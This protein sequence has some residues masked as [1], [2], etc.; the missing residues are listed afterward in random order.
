MESLQ[1][2][3]LAGGLAWASGIR[4][5]AAVFIA[6]VLGRLGYVHLPAGLTML[7]D[8][9]VIGV[10]AVLML[11]EFLAD[12]IPAFDSVWDA[13]H[14]FIRIPAGMLLAWGVFKDSGP[15]MQFAAALIGG[16]ITSGTHLTK[17]GTRALINTSPEPFSNWGASLVEDAS[18]LGGLYLVWAHPAI[19]LVLLVLFLA[20]ALWLLPKLFRGLAALWRR[21]RGVP[22]P[23]PAA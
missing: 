13:L 18:L 20:F 21:F 6:G 19:F 11:G 2:I 5:Y 9:W 1:N 3:A 8:D 4:L 16:A 17:A 7:Q 12:K 10:S 14:T 22:P 15:G 23:L